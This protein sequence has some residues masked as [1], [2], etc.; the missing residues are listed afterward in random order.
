MGSNPSK[1]NPHFTIKDAIP[2]R[3]TD[4]DWEELI[5]NGVVK[6]LNDAGGVASTN[7]EKQNT[8][9]EELQSLIIQ[10]KL[11]KVA[12]FTAHYI[13]IFWNLP[14]NLASWCLRQDSQSEQLFL[15]IS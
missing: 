6:G 9:P 11:V 2:L 3:F 13:Y 8:H 12:F 14:E 7:T 5:R 10:G 15:A 1:N 4:T